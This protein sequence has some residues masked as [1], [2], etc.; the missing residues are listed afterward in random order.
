[1]KKTLYVTICLLLF[2]PYYGN[3]DDC[4]YLDSTWQTKQPKTQQRLLSNPSI[5]ELDKH[6]FIAFLKRLSQQSF[7]LKPAI[8]L[9]FLK[10][11]CTSVDS[12]DLSV[13][14]AFLGTVDVTNNPEF[15]NTVVTL[16][17]S[18]NGS[19]RKKFAW[20]EE[21]GLYAELDSLY[22]DLFLLSL[23]DVYELLKWTRIK[24][25][26]DD[27]N[28]AA[29]IFCEI[30]QLRKNFVSMA[31]SQ[32]VQL[33][34]KADSSDI[35]RSAL[36]IYKDCYV[37]KPDADTLSLSN[38]LSGVYARF[39]LYN[40]ENRAIVELDRDEKS[41]GERLLAAA[42]SRFSKRLY[43][44]AVE[45][46]TQ[47]W[48]YLSTERQRNRCAK[49]LYQSY[50]TIGDVDSAMVWLEKITLTSEPDKVSAVVFYQEAGLFK[51]ADDIISALKPS[52]YRDTLTIR[53]FLYEGKLKDACSYTINCTQAG[54][55][56]SANRDGFLWKMRTSAFSG[57]LED[58]AL[59]L[60]SIESAG[61]PP[62][63]H[64]MK[65]VLIYRMAIQR[66]GIDQPG[67][68]SWGRLHYFIYIKKPQN[69]I[70]SII[71]EVWPLDIREYLATT[72]LEALINNKLYEKAQYVLDMIPEVH[73]SSQIDYFHALISFK[74]GYIEK[75]KRKFENIIVS[76]PDGVFSH[77]ARIYLLKINKIQTM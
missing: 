48:K 12:F 16:W 62:S 51:K 35:Q 7:K 4:L 66:M 18:Y 64:Y 10:K 38:W 15:S 46:A 77:K 53:Q 27:Y 29:L 59:F 69:I 76:D 25:I 70:D 5:D 54:H 30:S 42:Q 63:W 34:A 55:W 9:S 21:R 68:I 61:F 37:S 65:D 23:L 19:I 24:S 39:N 36:E 72:L 6:C 31:Q 52:L 3:T 45:P 26:L 49:L 71:K 28:G 44:E 2:L 17:E 50:A 32:F 58:A 43:E 40:E 8:L 22:H 20:Y 41:R 57:M 67:F 74:M 13:M 1:M 14:H 60:D 75:A 47:S 11:F 33:L 56:R 73:T